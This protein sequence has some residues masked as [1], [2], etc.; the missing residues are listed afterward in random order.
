VCVGCLDTSS[1]P[2]TKWKRGPDQRSSYKKGVEASSIAQKLLVA[3]PAQ[4]HW[5]ALEATRYEKGLRR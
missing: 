2:Q 1:R 5:K 3:R 4:R